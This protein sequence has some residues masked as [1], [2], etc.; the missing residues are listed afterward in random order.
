VAKSVRLRALTR[1]ERRVLRAKVQDRRLSVRLHRRY[2]LIAEVAGGRSMVETADRV[3]CNITMVYEWVHPVQPER[4]HHVRA[5]AQSAGAAAD[6]HRAPGP[7]VDRHCPIQSGRTGA[8]VL[9]LD[10]AQVGRVLPAAWRAAAGDGRVGSSA[11]AARRAAGPAHPD[12][13]DLR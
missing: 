6:H 11:S 10:G 5:A 2:R 3:G 12:L 13:E 4:L 9:S 8:A 1:G 7:R